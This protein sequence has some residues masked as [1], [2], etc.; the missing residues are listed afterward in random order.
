[1]RETKY[2]NMTINCS[3]EIAVKLMIVITDNQTI[4]KKKIKLPEKGS[5]NI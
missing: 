4:N 5:A 1:M 3:F 2:I